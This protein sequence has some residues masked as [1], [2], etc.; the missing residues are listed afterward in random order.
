M[1]IERKRQNE[2]GRTTYII[3]VDDYEL[4]E[5]GPEMEEQYRESMSFYDHKSTLMGLFG[6]AG[7]LEAIRIFKKGMEKLKKHE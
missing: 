5:I 6:L 2:I 1:V 7:S 4:K 3:H